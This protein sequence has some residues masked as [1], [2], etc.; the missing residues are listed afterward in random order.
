MRSKWISHTAAAIYIMRVTYILLKIKAF[1]GQS[2]FA[3]LKYIL[4]DPEK[5]RQFFDFV[6]KIRYS[7]HQNHNCPKKCID[8]VGKYGIILLSNTERDE[9][10]CQN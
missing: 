7:S 10:I 3:A 8:K 6:S 9:D 1:F 2:A 5:R 4:R